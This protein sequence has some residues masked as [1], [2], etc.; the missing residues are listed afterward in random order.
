[1]SLRNIHS[2]VI[3]GNTFRNKDKLRDLLAQYNP[4]KREWVLVIATHPMNTIKLRPELEK[5]IEELR[6]FGCV[7]TYR[8]PKDAGSSQAG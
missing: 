7:L 2:V 4:Q 5:R 3:T 1:M 8:T 6:K